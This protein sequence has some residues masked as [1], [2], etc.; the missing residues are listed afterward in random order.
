[1]A[2]RRP[3]GERQNPPAENK[4]YEMQQNDPLTIGITTVIL[5][6]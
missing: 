1:M 4:T 3:L 2:P 5:F 6:L